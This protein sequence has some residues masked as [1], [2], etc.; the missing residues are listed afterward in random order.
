MKKA[1]LY[2]AGTAAAIVLSMCSTE[3]LSADSAATKY[4]VPRLADG[5]PDLQGV[6][7]NSTATPFERSVDVH[8]SHLRKKLE[9]KDRELI[10]TVRGV[11]YLFCPE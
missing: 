7:T 2:G 5:T 10:R 11:G 6:W 9:H 3:V 1:F 4:K 8:V